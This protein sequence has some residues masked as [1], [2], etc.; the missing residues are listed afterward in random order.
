ML[1][2]PTAWP[3]STYIRNDGDN[4]SF[5]WDE[6]EQMGIAGQLLNTQSAVLL[7]NSYVL[8]T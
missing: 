4:E 3:D 8:Y 7:V 5:S 1:C 6:G 2:Y